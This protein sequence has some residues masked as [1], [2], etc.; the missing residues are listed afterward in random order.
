MGGRSDGE[1]VR[2]VLCDALAGASA[3]AIAAT[4][5]CPLDVIK[6]RL[7]VRGPSEVRL[8]S[9]RRTFLHTD[10]RLGFFT[11][12]SLLRTGIF[13]YAVYLWDNPIMVVVIHMLV[14]KILE[15]V[16]VVAGGITKVVVE[17]V[18]HYKKDCWSVKVEN[19]NG[20]AQVAKTDDDNYE[21]ILFSAGVAE[22]NK[23]SDWYLDSGCSN[24]M[25]GK[26]E[27][28]SD[29]DES[30]R[31]TVKFG[32]NQ[33]V[34][35]MGKACILGKKHRDSFPI[36][37]D[38][39]DFKDAVAYDRWVK[40]MHRGIFISQR[41][42]AGDILKKFK[43]DSA[44]SIM[45]PAEE[46][47]RLTKD[48]NGGVVNSTYFKSLVGSLSSK[49]LPIIALST[50]EAKFIAA[51][52][53]A[54]QAVWLRRM[55]G[56]LQHKQDD[57]TMVCCDSK[58]TIEL[59]KNPV[60]HGR[61]KH[62]DIK[63]HFIRDLVRE[64]EIAVNY[65]K[66]EF[67]VADIFTKGLK[68]ETF[69]KLK[70]MLGMEN[71]A[72]LV[73]NKSGYAQVAKTDDDNY[74][75]ILFSAGVVEENKNSDWY[76]DSGC[77]NHLCGKKEDFSD[78]DESFRSTVKFGNN[79]VVPVMGK[80][81]LTSM[82][83]GY[84]IRDSDTFILEDSFPIGNAWRARQ[85]LELIHSDLCS[86]EVPSRGEPESPQPPTRM[87]MDGVDERGEQT[88]QS[89]RDSST[90]GGRPRRKSQLPAR[91][92]DYVVGDMIDHL[93]N[94]DV[95]NFAL[96]VDCD[97]VDFKD[98]VAYDR[99]G[100]AMHTQSDRGIFIFQRKYTSDILKKFKMDSANSIMTPTEERL[101]L[102]KDGNGGVVNSTYFM[103]LVGSLSQED[104]EYT[105]AR[106]TTSGYAFFIGSGV[107]FW[108]SKKQ[109]VIA[110]STAEVEYIAPSN[111][112]T[113]AVWLRRMLGFLQHKQDDSTMVFC[114]SKSAI[115]L[116]KNPVFYGRSKHFDIRCHFIRDLVREN[117]IAV[118][119]CKSEDQVADIFTKRLK[120]ETF[121]KLKKML[122][123]ENVANLLSST[124]SIRA[125]INERLENSTKKD[126]TENVLQA[127]LQKAMDRDNPIMVVVIHMLVVKI[128]EL[129]AVVAVGITKVVVEN[130]SDL[131]E[132]F[133]STVKFGNNQVVLVMG[134]DSIPITLK[135][136][137]NSC[138]GGV[139]CVADLHNLLSHGQLQEKNYDLN[140]RR[141]VCTIRDERL[142]LIVKVDMNNC[143]L[144]P[145]TLSYDDL[146]CEA[147]ILGKKHRDSFLIG[148]AWRARQPLELTR[149]DL[150]LVEV[151]SRG[152][153]IRRKL[154]DKAEKCIFIGYSS[155]T[156]GYKL[157]N[158][159]TG[160]VII[161]KDV[162][163]DELGEPESP[164]P[165][166]PMYMDGVDERSKLNNHF[167]ILLLLVML[168]L[169]I[170]GYAGDILK[171]FKMDSANSIMTSAEERLRLTKDGNGGVVNSTYFKSLVGS[172]S[173]WAGDTVE[174]E[175]FWI[176]FFH[177][178][179]SSKEHPVI[180]LS[181]AEVEY[182]ASS[183]CATQAVWLRRMLGFLQHKQDDLT[184]LS[185]T[186][187]IR[188]RFLLIMTNRSIL[189]SVPKLSGKQ[190]YI[191]WKFQM[192]THLTAHKLL[193]YVNE[194]LAKD[195][196]DDDQRRDSLA[197]SQMHLAIDMFVF[198]KISTAK[199]AKQA[200]DILDK[201]YRGIDRVE[202][203]NGHAQVAKIGDDNHE[204]ILFSAGVA[205]VNK[206]SVWYLD[207]GCSNRMCGKKEN[208][209]DLDESFQSTMKFGNNQVVPVMGKGSIPITLENGKKSCIGGVYCVPNL[210]H[211]LLS[212]GQ[213]QEKNYDLNF[214]RGVC[215]IRD[216]RLS[217]I[218]KVDMNNYWLFPITLS[219]DDLCPYEHTLYVKSSSAGDILIVCL[220]VDDLIYTRNNQKMMADFRV[221][222][223]R[224][225]E[226]MDLGLM[227]FFL[228][229][230]VTQ[231]DRGI[232][233]SKR[234]YTGD[235]LKKFKKDSANSIMTPAE[236]RLRLTKDGN[237]GVV[238]STYFK[239]LILENLRQSHLQ[240]ANRILRYI[241]GTQ[242]DGILYAKGVFVELL[243]YTDSDWAGD[244][245]VRKSTS[246]Y[247]FFIGSVVFFWS[248]KKQPVIA[249]STAVAEYIPTSNCATQA[250]W[251]KRML[252]FLQHK[253][254]DS[255]MVYF[256]V[257][258]Q[259][260]S[261]LHSHVDEN[262][263]HSIG[264]NVLAAAGAGAATAITTNPLWV[265]KTRL[266]TQGMRD[267]VEPYKSMLSA[268][269]RITLE[270][271]RKGLYSGLLPSLVGISHVAIQF[272]SYEKIKSYLARK[273]NTSVDRLSPSDVAIASSLSKIIAS[274]LTYPH[275]ALAKRALLPAS[276]ST[277][278]DEGKRDED[279]G[280]SEWTMQSL[281][282]LFVNRGH[283]VHLEQRMIGSIPGTA[284]IE[285]L[286]LAKI[287]GKIESS[288]ETVDEKLMAQYFLNWSRACSRLGP[289][290]NLS[291]FRLL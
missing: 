127:L 226:M 53:C 207:S 17:L 274:T 187:G 15:L 231:S 193:K 85:P 257:Y 16:G 171:K 56:F 54:T 130:F 80:A 24:H 51:S 218:A 123:M 285:E 183:N 163:L 198:V 182:I 107:F 6:T 157:F 33:V 180:A 233:I 181:T 119:Y 14:V 1:N 221:V 94:E 169:M 142:G 249:L 45:T 178:F 203:K 58:S 129:V 132:S 5:V 211:N 76:L 176:C 279:S 256:T 276:K 160:K 2:E 241:K 61:S 151:P 224:Q 104:L 227:S 19:K 120:M 91:L 255:T 71:V 73:E 11:S 137:K 245:V 154:D 246:G 12:H 205:E 261:L 201:T 36:D 47:L 136:G 268:L 99:W 43:M 194:D 283:R 145:I 267:D 186:S 225:F 251:L 271:G 27:D 284:S 213:L 23:N 95:V 81:Q 286:K 161:S 204:T 149:L 18:G 185:S 82:R 39:V 153:S 112:A 46:R 20:H 7:Q 175:H 102:T 21:T 72:N 289:T 121:M 65:C 197:L 235:I 34:P 96:F 214:R 139:Y 70:K 236:E 262:K 215:T 179:W 3:G 209:S 162:T 219:H 191:Y 190:N 248:S 229:I 4:F 60:F 273:E 113:Q 250:V 93:T 59:I 103:S 159:D 26:K 38:P 232:F 184:M 173:D 57:W 259:L 278:K 116:T 144:F 9:S 42:Y 195:A 146:H 29:L 143:W 199:I 269:R 270:E 168:L 110:L 170:V 212:V 254:D 192:E 22:E 281:L 228:G 77:S 62:I 242:G 272:P 216:E 234:K 290:P 50:A 89:F 152:D 275:E 86:V 206:N 64:I 49:K 210:H 30:F 280:G 291:K 247:A 208:F 88:Q 287:L 83:F 63:Y 125:R 84:G 148:N 222:M 48:G 67:Q 31:S 32:N 288:S 97:P 253:Q 108:S 266:Q 114:D 165:P 260:K 44:N 68:E 25:C 41:K 140:F 189:Y 13:I 98:A 230:E 200:W 264:A 277:K 78:L 74:E 220:Y 92:N 131:D 263:E 124:S 75:T 217:L 237:G 164:Q 202:N 115:E 252:G 128:L 258:N 109:P 156:K 118:N 87:Y 40:A 265:V 101:K 172:L 133:R 79:Q 282:A 177:W 240:A 37:C 117:E 238:N 167:V 105:V 223:I 158:P 69:M 174:R 135:Y 106:K 196:D 126:S 150:C 244:T 138:I 10:T 141:G 90:S 8:Y 147:C 155:E 239:S 66:N 166:A 28:F 243:G 55:L 100:K 111:C 188:D 35:V 122:A 134:K 52:N